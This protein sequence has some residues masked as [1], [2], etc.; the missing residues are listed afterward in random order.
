MEH[1]LEWFD[2]LEFLPLENERVLVFGLE[3]LWEAMIIHDGTAD[4]WFWWQDGYNMLVD[5]YN[6]WADCPTIKQLKDEP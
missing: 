2:G 1:A 4:R 3:G 5:D 6:H